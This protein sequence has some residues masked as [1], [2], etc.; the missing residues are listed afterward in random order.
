MLLETVKV[1]NIEAK[2]QLIPLVNLP[3]NHLFWE[4]IS[5]ITTHTEGKNK[6]NRLGKASIE[7]SLG[8]LAGEH[9]LEIPFLVE[10]TN[11]LHRNNC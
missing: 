6:A 10:I 4:Q 2:Y 8:T 3:V 11:G 9:I 5:L 1:V 7:E